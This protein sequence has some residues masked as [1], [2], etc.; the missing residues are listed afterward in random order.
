M[1]VSIIV[2]VYNVEAYLDKCVE[3]LLAQDL[4]EKEYEIVLVDDGSTDGSGRICDAYA[5]DHANII[6]IHQ[7]NRGLSGARNTGIAAASGEY[8]QFVD[9]DDYLVPDVLGTLVRQMEESNLDILRFNYQNVNLSGEVFEPNKYSKP[10]VDFSGE[11]CDG[12]TFLNERLGFACYACQF[13]IKASIL[14]KEGNE[15]R[16]GIFFED[17]EW[18]PR[19]LLQAQRVASTEAVVYSY[20]FRFDSIARNVDLEKKRKSIRDK[21]SIL[22]GFDSLQGGLPDIRW[23]KGM[24]AQSVLSILDSIGR[25]FYSERKGYIKELKQKVHFPLSTYHATPSARRKI[26]LA[27]VSPSL[28]CCLYHWKSLI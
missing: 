26:R 1:K 25:F 9:S 2:P 17:V 21:L 14:Q 15:F 24:R 6:A 7:K 22:E 8:V 23:F 10:F 16:E 11:V 3:S 27:N 20:L 18:T 5:A 12:I 19:I 13:L 28:V 4:P